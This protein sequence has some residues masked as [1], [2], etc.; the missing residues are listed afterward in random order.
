[1]FRVMTFLHCFSRFIDCTMSSGIEKRL[2]GLQFIFRLSWPE[3]RV[4]IPQRP[5]LHLTQSL[6]V[7]SQKC[8]EYLYRDIMI[9]SPYRENAC[10]SNFWKESLLLQ[11]IKWWFWAHGTKRVQERF[12]HSRELS[13][14]VLL[15]RSPWHQCQEICMS[16]RNN[17][18]DCFINFLSPAQILVYS[19]SLSHDCSFFESSRHRWS[20][21]NFE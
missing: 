4:W 16:R 5:S 19:S 2:E 1:M 6:V 7:S 18:S 12:I 14:V 21:C 11:S 8:E 9:Q 17:S 20:Y 10:N 3:Q 15:L 13:G